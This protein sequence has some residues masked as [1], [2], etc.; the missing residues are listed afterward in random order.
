MPPCT[1]NLCWFL[2]S[3]PYQITAEELKFFKDAAPQDNFRKTNLGTAS[4]YN[5]NFKYEGLFANNWTYISVIHN[6][7][8]IEGSLEPIAAH[9][10]QDFLPFIFPMC[11]F[12]AILIGNKWA[13]THIFSAGWPDFFAL[14]FFYHSK[15]SSVPIS[16]HLIINA[17]LGH[18]LLIN[19]SVHWFSQFVA[20]YV[21]QMVI[22]DSRVHHRFADRA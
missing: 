21:L 11:V 12:L 9:E 16:G 2:K 10:H 13:T 5:T 17:S 6:K 22:C 15:N 18:L 8:I 7:Y 20:F 3:D 1:R 19:F 4:Q 14:G